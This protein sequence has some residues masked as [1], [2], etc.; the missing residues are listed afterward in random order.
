[1]SVAAP[2]GRASLPRRDARARSHLEVLAREV[3]PA[4]AAAERSLPVAGSL[5]ELLPGGGL[6]RGSVVTVGGEPGSG[7]TTLTLR[8]A[9]AAT[10]AGEW[11]AFVDPDGNLGGRAAGEAGVSLERCA[12]VRGVPPARW[13]TVVAALLD[14]VA[15]VAAVAPPGL[16]LGDARRLVARARERAAVLVVM[17]ASFPAGSRRPAAWPAEAA[18]RLTAEGSPWPGLSAGEGL[19]VQR[20]LRVQVEGRGGTRCGGVSP[21]SLAG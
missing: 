6:Q 11:V 20:E 4:V 15:F 12:F 5:G 14:G 17:E 18:L 1:M 2:T 16:R 9:A 3:R 21:V 13:P 7:S 8:L 10:S 19:L